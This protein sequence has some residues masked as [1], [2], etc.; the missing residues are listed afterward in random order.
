MSG[1][2]TLSEKTIHATLKYH[3]APN[4]KYHE[5]P[6]G[7]YIADICVDGEITEIQTRHF[8][9][10]RNKLSSFL[11]EHEVTIVHP[12][13]K[14]K[15][16]RYINPETGEISDRKKS[17]KKGSIYSIMPE[18]Y[19]I[20]SFLLDPHLHFTVC[21]LE[22]EETRFLNIGNWNPKR[23]T[24]RND[25]TPL[26]IYDEISFDIYSGYEQFLP[27]TLPNGFTSK[28]FKFHAHITQDLANVTLNILHHIG[29]VERVGK[30][31]NAYLYERR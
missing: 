14:E 12:V 25:G 29:L 3:Y 16:L 13:A 7:N 26:Q 15:W 30:Q 17:P 8:H 11:P 21:L 19:R 28:D 10:M 5:I 18:L 23:G 22:V 1:I 2:G 20:K 4:V 24:V 6:I 27:D 9:T 31:G